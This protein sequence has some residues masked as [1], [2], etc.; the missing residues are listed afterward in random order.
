MPK[1]RV[2]PTDVFGIAF[3]EKAVKIYINIIYYILYNMINKIHNVNT[4]V[5]GLATFFSLILLIQ[6]FTGSEALN[7]WQFPMLVAV[8]IETLFVYNLFKDD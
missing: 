6:S 3:F 5:I 8:F 7:T 2:S 4:F 1:I